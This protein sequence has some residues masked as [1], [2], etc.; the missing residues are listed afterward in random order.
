M[1]K[2]SILHIID[3]LGVG[4]AETLLIHAN[5]TLPGY[6]HIVVHL[7]EPNVYQHILK[8]TKVYYLDFQS[9]VLLP[10]V[11]IGLKR[12]IARH[13]VNIIHSHLYYSTIIARLACPPRVKL[14][15]SYHSLLYDPANKAQFSNKLLLLDRLT[16]R[17]YYYLLFVSTAVQQLVCQKVGIRGNYN[18]LYN[19]V[20][21]QY[22]TEN[23]N[24]I[25]NESSPIRIVMLGNLRPE[26]NYPFV[27]KA[28]ANQS[29][30]NFQMDIYGEGSQKSTLQ[31]LICEHQLEKRIKLKGWV[32][33]PSSVLQQYDFYI[34][35]SLFEGFGIALAE[36][37]ASGLPCVVSNIATHREVAGETVIYFNPT[38]PQSLEKEIRA[39]FQDFQKLNHL[40]G[41]S[42]RRAEKFNRTSYIQEL[43]NVYQKV[44]ADG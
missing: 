17:P 24:A 20:G 29:D 26:K 28:L 11:V 18:V 16:Y 37:M 9:W 43:D 3:S 15:S 8:H 41:L 33:Q 32:D 44:C 35:A 14:I 6:E 27:I 40:K 25:S 19:Y 21:D 5:I 31:K 4:G 38:D 12:I 13:C 34:A 7:R 42:K 10:K 1:S 30:Q 2:R 39:I 36:A 22:F 23:S